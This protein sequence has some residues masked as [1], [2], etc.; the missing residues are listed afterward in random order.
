MRA[1]DFG[2]LGKFLPAGM[3]PAASGFSE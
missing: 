1:P 3:P 2:S